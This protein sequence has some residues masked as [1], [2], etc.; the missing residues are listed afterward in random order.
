MN[1]EDKMLALI[2]APYIF[3]SDEETEQSMC[4]KRRRIW[5]KDWVLRREIM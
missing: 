5:V 1:A 3:E 2:L 4:A